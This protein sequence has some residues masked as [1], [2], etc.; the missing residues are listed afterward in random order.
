VALLFLVE[1]AVLLA[2]GVIVA[3]GQGAGRTALVLRAGA[4]LLVLGGVF[5]AWFVFS[6]D[7]YV[8]GDASRWSRRDSHVFV[9]A[10]WAASALVAAAL[11]REGEPRSTARPWAAALLAAAAAVAVLQA[12][13]AVSQNLN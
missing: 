11:W 13:A 1:A 5:L 10:A 8:N 4:V 2:G 3:R 9:Y 7:P 12:V 6:G